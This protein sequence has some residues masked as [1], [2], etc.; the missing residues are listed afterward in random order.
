MLAC[1]EKVEC[2]EVFPVFILEANVPAV[3]ENWPGEDYY[4][5]CVVMRS[6]NDLISLSSRVRWRN[7]FRK[8]WC[9]EIQV[10]VLPAG[11]KLYIKP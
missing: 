9:S 5:G 1:E 7:F 6:C 2:G 4:V 3:I 10:R 8:H 11:T